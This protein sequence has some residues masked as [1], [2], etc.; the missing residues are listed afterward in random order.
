MDKRKV[1]K[2]AVAI[3]EA[4]QQ[5]G[6]FQ[7]ASGRVPVSAEQQRMSSAQSRVI[8]SID[9][10]ITFG[11]ITPPM[12]PDPVSVSNS[13]NNNGPG[14]VQAMTH[15]LEK[16]L[17]VE[18]KKQEVNIRQTPDG[19]VLSLQEVGFYDAGSDVLRP[20]A[21]VIL[22]RLAHILTAY[23]VRLRIEG[24]TDNTPI[25]ND[26][27]ASNWEL[28][29]SRATGLV[30]LFVD[31]YSIPPGR[32][33]AAGYAEYHPLASNSTPEGRRLNRRIDVVV[34]PITPP[35]P[36]QTNQAAGKQDFTVVKPLSDIDIRDPRMA[37]AQGRD[38][39]DRASP[40]TR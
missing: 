40:E 23:G 30:R 10:E 9:R 39:P 33:A 4:F 14:S 1:G 29:T 17:A 28:S 37:R 7:E 20:G 18:I 36:A 5:L 38:R 13:G 32:L 34:L 11:R 3:Q 15:D 2:L 12:T 26:H 22:A 35:A 21:E 8:E 27:F 31:K 16:V 19:L 25:H 6:I 24:H